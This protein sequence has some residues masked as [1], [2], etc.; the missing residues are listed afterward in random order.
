[1]LDFV[2]YLFFMS[3]YNCVFFIRLLQQIILID[4]KVLN[5]PYILDLN[6]TFSQ[7]SMLFNISLHLIYSNI[8]LRTFAFML[9]PLCS[10]GILVLFVVCQYEPKVFFSS[11]V[12]HRRLCRT[13][14][15]FS[16]NV[17]QKLPIKP[18]GRDD[19]FLE[20]FKL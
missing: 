3:W 10:Q 13:S 11:S 9:T 16:L 12:F 18:P 7:C 14:V 4:F 2:K 20:G 1:M 6:L 15:Y 5:Q 8:L 17:W 19:F